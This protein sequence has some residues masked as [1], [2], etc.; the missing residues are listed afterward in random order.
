MYKLRKEE[1]DRLEQQHTREEQERDEM[2]RLLSDIHGDF[3]SREHVNRILRRYSEQS[4]GSL[5]RP[6]IRSFSNKNPYDDF[7][8]MSLIELRFLYATVV[9][10]VSE[11]PVEAAE[12]ERICAMLSEI[13]NDPASR[14]RLQKTLRSYL[15]QCGGGRFAATALEWS[16]SDHYYL[17]R[18]NLAELKMLYGMVEHIVSLGPLSDL[19][20]RKEEFEKQIEQLSKML[21]SLQSK[22]PPNAEDSPSHQN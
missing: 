16:A 19:F 6:A 15:R 14:D 5:G 11:V 12:R 1:R 13:H 4:R 21:E 9:N 10:I 3:E 2:I 8:K 22:L 7:R 17:G 20:D 18:L